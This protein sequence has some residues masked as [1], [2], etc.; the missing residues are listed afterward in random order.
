[1]IHSLR[2]FSVN[3]LRNTENLSISKVYPVLWMEDC[4]EMV[5]YVVRGNN[6]MATYIEVSEATI[7]TEE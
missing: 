4:G 2:S 5:C 3:P 6:G 1:M 7:E